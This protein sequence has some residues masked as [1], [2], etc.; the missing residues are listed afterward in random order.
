MA[1]VMPRE[2][3]VTRE[4]MGDWVLEWH[5]LSTPRPSRRVFLRQKLRDID[6]DPDHEVYTEVT[7]SPSVTRQVIQ[8]LLEDWDTYP[9]EYRAT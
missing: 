6:L 9:Q 4:M 3:P 7:S 8:A 5:N 2:F 1:V